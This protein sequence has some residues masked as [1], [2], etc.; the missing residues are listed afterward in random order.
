MK[1]SINFLFVF[2]VVIIGSSWSQEVSNNLRVQ[3]N[4][5]CILLGNCDD[6][7]L[8][9]C[10]SQ[11]EVDSIR[12]QYYEW[13]KKMF[14]DDTI[15]AE[16]DAIVTLH[17]IDT[18]PCSTF[19][20]AYNLPTSYVKVYAVSV[21][22]VLLVNVWGDFETQF[23]TDLYRTKFLFVHPY[24]PY[25]IPDQVWEYGK[26]YIAGVG[27]GYGLGD[28]QLYA[29]YD[30]NTK[31]SLKKKRILMMEYGYLPEDREGPSLYELREKLK[32]CDVQ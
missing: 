22:S 26:S 27:V 10:L 19:N 8:T 13:Q 4:I 7:H 25:T 15:W 5:D 32:R 12:N 28:I 23:K 30:S 18:T 14:W 20:M 6:L 9:D 17:F 31:I 24:N 3:E 16:Y 2:L 11:D 21:D 1:N 29:I